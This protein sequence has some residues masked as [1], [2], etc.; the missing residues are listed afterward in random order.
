M[1]YLIASLP[2]VLL[3]Y[4]SITIV[5][6]VEGDV[7]DEAGQP[8]ANVAIRGE[9]SVLV[10][11]P[12]LFI[13]RTKSNVAFFQ[14]TD[15]RGHYYFPRSLVFSMPI[16]E[17]VYFSS[18]KSLALKIRH[19]YYMPAWVISKR[20]SNN[21]TLINLFRRLKESRYISPELVDKIEVYQ[22]E[23]R[24]LSCTD[25]ATERDTMCRELV[26]LYVAPE[27]KP[28]RALLGSFLGRVENCVCK[29]KRS[30][31]SGRRSFGQVLPEERPSR[32]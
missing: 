29:D 7:T 22:T 19:P 16:F 4:L 28:Q 6:P 21:V 5:G 12:P 15:G 14:K 1:K 9:T 23:F 30:K 2:V 26:R 31:Q 17:T 24:N 27:S 18:S 32:N 10:L 8:I 3:A 11:T 13:Y 25:Y 20:G